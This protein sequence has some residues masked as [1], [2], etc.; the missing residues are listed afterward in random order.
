MLFSL[1]F[2][3]ELMSFPGFMFPGMQTFP[4][5]PIGNVERLMAFQEYWKAYEAATEIINRG[6]GVNAEPKAHRLRAQ[7]ALTMQMSKEAIESASV[8][9]NK[10]RADPDEIA[11]C[12][13]IRSKAYLQMGN[14]K[15][16][17]A[18]AKKSKDRN[19]I[20]EANAATKLF[21]QYKELNAK[22]DYKT[23]AQA[24]D[25]ILSVASNSPEL[26][27]M[28]SE[29]AWELHDYPKFLEVAKDLP[30]EYPDDVV[31]IYRLGIVNMCNGKLDE[32]STKIGDAIKVKGSTKEYT[33]VKNTVKVLSQSYLAAKKALNAQNTDGV[34][35]SLSKFFSA[36]LNYCDFKSD[37]IKSANIL[38]AKSIR[39]N[40]D[41]QHTLEFLN[42]MI[43]NYSDT[44]DFEIERGEINLELGDYDG[45]IFDF[46]SVLRKGNNPRARQGLEKAQKL[47][48]EETM[49]DYYKI[50]GC[51]RDAS[52]SEIKSAFRKATIKWH[53]DR[54]RDKQQKQEAEAMM[55]K[56]NV[57]YEVL[58]DPQKKMMYDQGIDPEHPENNYGNGFTGDMNPFEQIFNM[59][60]PFGG[61]NFNGQGAHFQ[62]QNGNVHF[63]FHFG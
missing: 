17:L 63:E 47:K 29:L 60:F 13:K 3:I 14:L 53:P 21:N 28:R 30:K 32:A 4:N 18:D 36:G 45:A 58:S 44:T 23:A 7:C 1:F 34:N 22:K 54:Y 46:Q 57:A 26:K 38:K 5:T 42:D 41:P 6:G 51:P 61:F 37:L 43:S 8:V 40:G 49:V 56:I 59:G 2:L 15:D 9:I 50:L 25:K 24:L 55:K 33:S 35:K 20:E 27:K 19:A 10:K 62:G 39:L 11:M 16:C 52:S 31:L 48:R 12:Y